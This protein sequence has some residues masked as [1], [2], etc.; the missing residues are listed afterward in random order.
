VVGAALISLRG[1][2]GILFGVFDRSPGGDTGA[3]TPV[4][5]AYLWPW[6]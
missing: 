4:H 6:R 5:H 2:I 1:G 3:G